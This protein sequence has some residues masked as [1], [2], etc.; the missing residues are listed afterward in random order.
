MLFWVTPIK[1]Q[2]SDKNHKIKITTKKQIT[3]N[4]EI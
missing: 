4:Y 1:C 2:M 3:L